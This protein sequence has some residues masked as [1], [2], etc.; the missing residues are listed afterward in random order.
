VE[1]S[2]NLTLDASRAMDIDNILTERIERGLVDKDKAAETKKE[3]RKYM[4]LAAFLTPVAKYYASEAA[5]KVSSDAIQVLG[6]S[7]FMR[8]YPL[9]RY[10]RDSRITPIYEGTSQLQVV[11][12]IRGVTSGTAEAY[13][14]E[15]DK[16]FEGEA[17]ELAKMLRA[18][19]AEL[20][21][22]VEYAKAKGSDYTDLYARDLVDI[23]VDT[24]IGYLFLKQAAKSEKKLILAKHFIPRAAIRIAMLAKRAMSG[25][26]TT[27]EHFEKIAGAPAATT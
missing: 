1:A 18:G 25:D 11:A 27:L 15:L 14:E 23:A 20:K 10:W 8:D 4:R 5:V 22:A 2:R 13:L 7:G 16:G 24:I 19:R 26:T 6:G 9:E 21:K 12:A 3:Q 17:E